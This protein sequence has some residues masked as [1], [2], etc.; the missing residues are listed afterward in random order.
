VH[1][2]PDKHTSQ[3]LAL[4]GDTQQFGVREEGI[5]APQTVICILQLGSTAAQ[6]CVSSCNSHNRSCCVLTP[7]PCAMCVHMQVHL[8]WTPA[9]LTWPTC[10]QTWS[11]TAPGG[12]G[13]HSSRRGPPSWGD[14]LGGPWVGR[15]VGLWG[16]RLEVRVPAVVIGREIF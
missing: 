10:A 16:D 9:S 3:V 4:A 13:P 1:N 15:L 8:V 12:T 5:T 2:L 14:P 11:G 6:C 7:P